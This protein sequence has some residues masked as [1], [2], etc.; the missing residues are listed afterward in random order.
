MYSEELLGGSTGDGEFVDMLEDFEWPSIEA[1]MEQSSLTIFYK[2]HSGTVY[3][4]KD[5]YLTRSKLK[6]KTGAS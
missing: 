2:F 3:L 1:H 5:K 4:E 6:K